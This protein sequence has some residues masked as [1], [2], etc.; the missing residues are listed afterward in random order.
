MR[1]FFLF[2]MLFSTTSKAQINQNNFKYFKHKFIGDSLCLFDGVNLTDFDASKIDT[3]YAAD[4]R[5]HI[6]TYEENKKIS[7]P[8][9]WG[10]PIVVYL[11]KNLSKELRDDFIYFISLIPE[12]QNL[13]ISYTKN[14]NESNYYIKK[15]NEIIT[16]NCLDSLHHITYRLITDNS[17]KNIGGVLKINPDLFESITEQKKSLR[18]FFF[19]SLGQFSLR[20]E[21]KEENSIMTKYYQL[22]NELSN[23]DKVILTTHYNY[24]NKFPLT[25]DE[26][27]FIQRKIKKTGNKSEMYFKI[28]TSNE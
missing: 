26:F 10:K 22:S 23:Y 21:K 17:Y 27:N 4:Y 9:H 16:S 24:Y 13:K 15:T 3:K 14:I 2:C 11:D 8:R 19:L 18:Q 12:N 28:N 6:Y 20:N 25:F 5:C 1:Y 7:I